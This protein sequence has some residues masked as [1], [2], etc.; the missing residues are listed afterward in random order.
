MSMS[1]R[2]WFGFMV[3]LLA[4]VVSVAGAS[5]DLSTPR[6][7]AV[8]LHEAIEQADPS[9]IVQVLSAR[10]DD[11]KVLA[12]SM[13]RLIVAGRHLRSAALKRWGDAAMPLVED[14]IAA[15]ELRQIDRATITQ[16][17]DR[18]QLMLADA[19]RPITFIRTDGKW[20]L[21][22]VDFMGGAVGKLPRQARLLDRVGDILS[23]AAGDIAGGK[24]SSPDTAREDL[25][26]KLN[27]AM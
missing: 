26:K 12:L 11:Q 2:N 10:T 1:L 9:A 21:D 27:H 7:A 22:I 4:P 19:T 8:A 6:S 15:D 17:D 5:P 3:V 14:M 25:I 18:A 13:A 16:K 20:R 23:Q 24:Y